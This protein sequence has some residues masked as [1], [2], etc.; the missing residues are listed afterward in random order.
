ML[1][2][3]T[4]APYAFE[5]VPANTDE[6]DAA[7]EILDAL[8]PDSNV[9]SDKG[10]IGDEWQSNW[11]NEGIRIWTNKR[12]NQK[13]QNPKE[14]DKML[15][16][17]RERV[18]GAFDQLKEGGRSVEKTLAKTIDGL[19]SRVITKITSMIYRAFL[20]KFYFIDLLTYTV[21]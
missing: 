7:D 8:P 11:K 13:T 5:L 16:S 14:F 1:T 15:N 4:G 18:E 21:S 17:V 9:W 19:C 3:L 6:R 12:A 2:T 20:K 10:F